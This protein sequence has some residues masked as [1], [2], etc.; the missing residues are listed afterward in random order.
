[1][2]TI[3]P[4]VR[5]PIVVRRVKAEKEHLNVVAKGNFAA[6]QARYTHLALSE[7]LPNPAKPSFPY[8]VSSF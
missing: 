5:K 3:K 6:L 7:S 2:N 1:M 8:K 4:S